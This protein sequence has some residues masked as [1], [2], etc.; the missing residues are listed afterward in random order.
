MHHPVSGVLGETL[1]IPC[2]LHYSIFSFFLLQMYEAEMAR[3][4]QK[5]L[6]QAL[7]EERK[8]EEERAHQTVQYQEQLEK[9][10]EE[11]VFI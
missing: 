9:Q 4:M 11:Q 2:G 3:I 5:E 1:V 6:Q 7:E 8:R 10:L